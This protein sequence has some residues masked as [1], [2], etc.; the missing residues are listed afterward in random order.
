M[1][2]PL[3]P[4]SY[5]DDPVAGLPIGG[6]TNQL[7]AKASAANFDTKWVDAPTGGGGTVSPDWARKK[8]SSRITT[9]TQGLDATDVNIWEFVHLITDKPN[10]NDSQTWDWAPAFRGALQYIMNAQTRPGGN[11]TAFSNLA[12]KVPANF[13]PLRSAVPITRNNSSTYPQDFPIVCIRGDGLN[14]TILSVDA[15]NVELFYISGVR[16]YISD[17][18]VMG[19]TNTT[20]F[21][22]GNEN[23]EENA[24]HLSQM[25]RGSIKNINIQRVKK[26]MIFG[27]VMDSVFENIFIGNLN[28]G[29]AGDPAVGL[30][31][32]QHKFDNCNFV[33]IT[34]LHLEGVDSPN[35]I[36]LRA[37]GGTVG[38]SNFHQNFTFITP[39]FETRRYDAKMIDLEG[40]FNF[41]F[42]NSVL[43][44]SNDASD[45]TYKD[46][47]PAIRVGMSS[48]EVVFE[49]GTVQHI[50]TAQADMPKLLKYESSAY[51]VRFKNVK[52]AM[53]NSANSQSVVNLLDNQ[54]QDTVMASH[55][56]ED[57]YFGEIEK[58]P[59]TLS[60]RVS[61]PAQVN[62]AFVSRVDSS[63][64]YS[65]NWGQNTNGQSET[66]VMKVSQ[67]GM[68]QLPYRGVK[69]ITIA[70]GAT[71]TIYPP[72]TGS[73]NPNNAGRYSLIAFDPAG[74]CEFYHNWGL[75]QQVSV[76]TNFAIG[77]SD[78]AVANKIN[79]YSQDASIK[80]AVRVRNSTSNPVVLGIDF[81]GFMN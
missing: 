31:I 20:A 14:N 68:V 16:P 13:Y 5:G 10:P 57:C 78:P 17:F 32:L 51:G 29:T 2:K 34:Q 42:I 37:R 66:S 28:S 38:A 11:G 59:F 48:R 39:H 72:N 74:M 4:S 44:R 3:V 81:V 35:A 19:S 71:Y 24:L 6:G 75:I 69:Q 65:L 73:L 15:D 50:G 45:L 25:Q 30:D 56:F 79:V 61:N 12:L 33:T 76:G 63:G 26:G 49:G 80:N 40:T 60:Q 46:S 53:A 1:F 21:H 18:S 67:N 47:Q 70:A 9:I 43:T 27:W 55:S 62:Q 77:V 52:F 8:L 64:Y 54:S 58:V 23:Q 36:Q 22:L 7:L 41:R